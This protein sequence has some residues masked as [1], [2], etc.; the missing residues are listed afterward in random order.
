MYSPS[1]AFADL[2]YLHNPKRKQLGTRIASGLEQQNKVLQDLLII[3]NIP[4]CSV[5][6]VF[7]QSVNTDIRHPKYWI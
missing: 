1:L 5:V 7:V 2:L 6:S 4:K 3:C